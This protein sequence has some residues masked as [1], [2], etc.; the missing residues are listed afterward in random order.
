MAKDYYDILGVARDASETEIKKAYRALAHKYHPDKAGGDEKKFK[1]VNEAYQVLSNKQKRAQYDQFGQSFGGAGGAGGFDFSQ[2]QRAGARGFDFNF[3]GG[4]FDD[5]FSQMF[6]GGVGDTRTSAHRTG[7]D[8][9]VDVE[10]SF[11]EMIAGAT[12]TITVYRAT[13]CAR[14]DGTGGEPDA[15][16]RTCSVCDGSG[17]VQKRMQTIL[18]TM[19]QTAVCETCHGRGTTYDKTCTRCKGVG[20][21]RDNVEETLEIPAGIAD[22]QAIAV[23]ERGEPGEFGARA[24][25]LIVT[26]HVV[27]DERFTRDGDNIRTRQHV[28]FAQAALGDKI[29]VETVDGPVKMKVPAGTQSGEQY[30]IR[31]KGV[32]KLRSL[33]RGDH[34]VEVIVDVPTSL[35]RTQKKLIT[36]LRDAA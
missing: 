14:C 10:I 8:V 1:E 21:Y 16:T 7:R 17:R 29:S 18:G 22:G 30:R 20:V 19:M 23:S 13:R 33:G 11:V 26:V 32:P 9:H 4:G 6:G 15:A 25:D 28:S 3:G 27:P 35:T 5:L 12:K 31:G 36:Q 2:F 24:G 34:I